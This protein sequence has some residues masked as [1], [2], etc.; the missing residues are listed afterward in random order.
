M[1]VTMTDYVLASAT[2]ANATQ[3]G[4]FLSVLHHTRWPRQVQ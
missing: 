4:S 3:I 1:S 2:L